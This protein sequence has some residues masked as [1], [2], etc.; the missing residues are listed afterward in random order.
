MIILPQNL[1]HIWIC[2]V[3]V[4]NVLINLHANY[5]CSCM[6]S[7][8]QFGWG[9]I[10]EWK[11]HRNNCIVTMFPFMSFPTIP[12]HFLCISINFL[13][14]VHVR[15][16]TVVIPS[17][18]QNVALHFYDEDHRVDRVQGIISNRPNW[19]P[20]HPLTRRRVGT[21]HFCSWGGHTRLWERG[22]L[23]GPFRTRGTDNLV[24]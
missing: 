9:I 20:S 21:L 4:K 5:T 11:G 15:V 24:L 3:N 17:K 14:C 10:I 7:H 18:G 1:W 22:C 8:D 16:Y 6:F 13:F 19:D 2:S 12:T 23:G